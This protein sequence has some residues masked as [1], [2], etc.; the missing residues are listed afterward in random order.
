MCVCGHPEEI[1]FLDISSTPAR[2]QIWV[3]SKRTHSLV[4]TYTPWGFVERWVQ[5]SLPPWEFAESRNMLSTR[6]VTSVRNLFYYSKAFSLCGMHMF[7]S[8]VLHSLSLHALMCVRG[9]FSSDFSTQES[10][11]PSLTPMSAVRGAECH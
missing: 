1:M 7:Q 2:S 11:R 4:V 6:L 5:P 8:C 3:H 10:P 9:D